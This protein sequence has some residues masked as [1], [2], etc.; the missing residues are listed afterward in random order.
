MYKDKKIHLIGIGGVSMSGI[1]Y[2]LQNLGAIV[3]GSDSAESNYTNNLINSGIHVV[4]GSNTNL[5]DKADIIVYSAAIKDTDKELSHAIKINKERYERAEFLGKLTK[6]YTNCLCISGTHGKSTTTGMVSNIFLEAKL[7]PTISI[8]ADLPIINSNIHIGNNDYLIMEACEYVDSFL[9]FHP[10]GAIVTNIDNDHL[11]YFKNL[12]NIKKSFGKFANLIP[13][14][15]YLVVNNDDVN[16]ESLINTNTNIITYGINNNSN[17]NAKNIIYNNIGTLSYDLYKNNEF[18]DTINLHVTGVHNVY[19]SLAAIAL[20]SNYINNIDT[21]KNGLEK[22]TGVGRRFEFIC[23]YNNALIYDDY[24]HHPT[25]LKTT[26]DSVKNI[27]CKNN[28]A[29]FQCHTYSRTKKHLESFADILS[30]FDNIII[31]P[32]YAAREENIYNVKEEDLVNLINKKNKNVIYLDS[33]EKIT[34]HL[35]KVIKEDD[36]VIT[37]GAGPI[38]KVAESFKE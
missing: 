17:F 29:V 36:L 33:F 38:N 28:Y 35:K 18:I 24:A 1:A 10:T 16:S 26:L 22:F 15:G 6:V 31:A 8:G 3:T 34:E 23:K 27:N 21:I 14:A 9:H 7:D 12:E 13:N 2:M 25:E 19:N 20:C 11:D 37:I 5:I 32:I 4:I 30:E